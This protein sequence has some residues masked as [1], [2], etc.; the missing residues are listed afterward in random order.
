ME[1]SRTILFGI[2]A[3]AALLCTVGIDIVDI[4][5]N[6]ASS[7]VLFSFEA[8]SSVILNNSNISSNTSISVIS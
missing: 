2:I 7:V 8:Y 1:R 6:D 3:C 5:L 4:F